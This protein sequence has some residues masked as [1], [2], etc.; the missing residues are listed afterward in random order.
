MFKVTV[1]IPE[2]VEQREF[3]SPDMMMIADFL[4]DKVGELKTKGLI[5]WKIDITPTSMQ[6]LGEYGV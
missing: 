4:Q 2:Y 1:H 5:S 3:I 6:Y